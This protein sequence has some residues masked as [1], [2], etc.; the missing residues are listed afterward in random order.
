MPHGLLGRLSLGVNAAQAEEMPRAPA[1]T[2]AAGSNYVQVGAYL[3]HG[4]AIMLR[5]ELAKYGPTSIVPARPGDTSYFRVRIGPFN[6]AQA[7][8][9]VDALKDQ[10]R[11]AMVIAPR[12]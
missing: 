12:Q 5:D 8:S 10:G 9:V 4:S 2:L 1:Q 6:E 7:D 11:I 3:S